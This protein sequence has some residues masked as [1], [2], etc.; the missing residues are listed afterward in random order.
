MKPTI[1]LD[2]SF[3]QGSKAAD[4]KALCDTCRVLMSDVLFY[5]MMSTDEA[6]RALCFSKFPAVDDPV[7]L[8][9][10]VGTL[11]HHEI[12]THT[13]CGP[14]SS[15]V[16]DFSFRFHPGLT[17][18]AHE[19]PE[20]TQA[21]LEQQ[22]AET[23]RDVA[24]FAERVN[25]TA[26]MFPGIRQG[27]DAQRRAAKVEAEKLI[28][29]DIAAISTF[30]GQ[31]E[32]PQGEGPLPAAHL[33][34]PS[35]AIFRWLQANLLIAL[36]LCWRYPHKST[37]ELVAQSYKVIEHDMLDAHYVIL[38]ALENSIATDDNNVRRL[39][40]LMCPAGNLHVLPRRRA[41]LSFR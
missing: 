8:V 14:P 10:N 26:S 3:L 21:R 4:I 24:E 39:W 19:L 35:W 40:S 23:Q 6:A 37:E 13:P 31:L 1:I 33:L 27:S 15:W 18:K 32:P 22:M 28:A 41:L 11:L 17:K 34:T 5:E 7:M 9:P 2:K 29:S 25:V 20:E 36:D 16:T 12:E 38:G 30:Y